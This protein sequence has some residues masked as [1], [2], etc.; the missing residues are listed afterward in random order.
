LKN[1]RIEENGPLY[2][3]LRIVALGLSGC[4]NS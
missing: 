2:V 4:R 1:H 3:V